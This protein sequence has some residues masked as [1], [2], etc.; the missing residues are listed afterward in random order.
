MKSNAERTAALE[1]AAFAERLRRALAGFDSQLL[2]ATALAREFNR[3]SRHT[4]VG[5]T[6]VHKWL[7]GEAIPRQETLTFLAQWL[8]VPVQWLRFGDVEP[9]A[10]I[11]GKERRRLD[12]MLSDFSALSERDKRLVERLM[13]EMLRD[14][15]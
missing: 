15:G 10:P 9:D 4:T 13:R 3:R 2:S 5:V 14:E 1:K 7:S 8:R 12:R 6:A 11:S